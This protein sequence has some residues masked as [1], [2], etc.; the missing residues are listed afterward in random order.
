MWGPDL[1][2]C[3]SGG[4]GAVASSPTSESGSG[5]V[6]CKSTWVGDLWPRDGRAVMALFIVLFVCLFL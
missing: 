6:W 4:V 5:R 3:Y 2:R 1:I